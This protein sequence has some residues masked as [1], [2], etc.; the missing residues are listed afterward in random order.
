MRKQV[1]IL[2][3]SSTLLYSIYL[4]E[5]C[6]ED[7]VQQSHSMPP[8]SQVQKV[9]HLYNKNRYNLLFFH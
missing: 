7:T 5:L 3:N 2:N 1:P 9:L 8:V 4:V 6:P